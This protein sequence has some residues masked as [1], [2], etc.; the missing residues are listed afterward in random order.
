[1]NWFHSKQVKK[2]YFMGMLSTIGIK[3]RFVF[4]PLL[5]FMCARE[6]IPSTTIDPSKVKTPTVA[7]WEFW[8]GLDFQISKFILRFEIR[9]MWD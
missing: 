9:K 4:T 2:I 6:V 3:T 5:H 1:M 8:L 7:K